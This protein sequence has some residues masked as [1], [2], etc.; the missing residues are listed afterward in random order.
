MAGQASHMPV[1]ASGVADAP[2]TSH[3]LAVRP[4]STIKG[5]TRSTTLQSVKACQCL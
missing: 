5:D 2:D 3:M 1:R 4:D